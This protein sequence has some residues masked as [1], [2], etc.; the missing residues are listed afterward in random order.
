MKLAQQIEILLDLQ[1]LED[2]RR[3][4][5]P[6][7]EIERRLKLITKRMEALA[8]DADEDELGEDLAVAPREPESVEFAPVQL[9]PDRKR[10]IL[11]TLLRRINDRRA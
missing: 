6:H 4:L 5:G 7:S 2:A 3:L 9:R 11:E 8:E 10:E 1:R